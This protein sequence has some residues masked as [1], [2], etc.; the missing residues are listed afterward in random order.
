MGV[1]DWL[2]PRKF[3]EGR[4]KMPAWCSTKLIGFR[5]AGYD[6][7]RIVLGSLLLLAAGLKCYQLG[8]G[9]VAESGLLTSRWF[10]ILVVEFELIFALF[11]LVGACRHLVWNGRGC[12]LRRFRLPLL[13]QGGFRRC[14]LRL[15]RCGACQPV[16]DFLFGYRCLTGV[17][18]ASPR[19]AAK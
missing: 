5:V 17:A 15:F 4:I 12:L 2:A 7:L 6:V 14:L 1:N 13:L 11:L 8:S 19:A 10:L 16:V 18:S 9:P 3:D